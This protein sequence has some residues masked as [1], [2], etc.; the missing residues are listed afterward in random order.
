[1]LEF[2]DLQNNAKQLADR[3]R[4]R[5]AVSQGCFGFFSSF[6]PQL[7]NNNTS[8]DTNNLK[9]LA[10]AL[11]ASHDSLLITYLNKTDVHN[12]LSD[13]DLLNFKEKVLIGMYLVIGHKYNTLLDTYVNSHFI[14]LLQKD[15]GLKVLADMGDE[16]YNESL[17]ALSLYSSFVFYNRQISPELNEVNRC[18]GKNIQSQIYQTLNAKTEQVPTEGC[19]SGI[20]CG[21]STS[22]GF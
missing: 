16:L 10:N 19:F 15:L 9:L 7:T 4:K 6:V 8:V 14:A 18:L 12:N 20:M 3:L 13:N 21:F 2:A 5:I 11:D 22:R 1:M 17:S